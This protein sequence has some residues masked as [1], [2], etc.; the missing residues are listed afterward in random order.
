M[1]TDLHVRQ[2]LLDHHS[3]RWMWTLRS[4]RYRCVPFC[5][6]WIRNLLLRHLRRDF[7]N[8]INKTVSSFNIT[9]RTRLTTLKYRKQ[10]INPWEINEHTFKTAKKQ[11]STHQHVR[12]TAPTKWQARTR[13]RARVSFICD[14]S[15]RQNVARRLVWLSCHVAVFVLWSVT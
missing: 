7:C 9:I 8:S 2:T 12:S 1:L 13:T 6:F 10:I 15:S 14:A 4:C 3:I 11:I 5:R